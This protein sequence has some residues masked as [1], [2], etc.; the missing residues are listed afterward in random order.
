MVDSDFDSQ[1]MS[2]FTTKQKQ[3]YTLFSH[4]LGIWDNCNDS[5]ISELII[6]PILVHKQL[7]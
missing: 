6:P 7:C 4:C 5:M 1:H 3:L 2:I